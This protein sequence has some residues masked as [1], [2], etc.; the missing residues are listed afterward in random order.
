MTWVA[1][2]LVYGASP[3]LTAVSL[4]AA[5]ASGVSVVLAVLVLTSR[6]VIYS[7][8]LLSR[9]RGQPG[10]FR[11]AGPYLLVDPLFALVIARTTESDSPAR[12]RRYYL[13]AGL[14]IWLVWMPSLA[15]GLLAGP[16]LP[17][18]AALEFALPALLIAFLVP[19]LT[20]RPALAAAAVGAAMGAIA[21][22][23]PGGA[24]LALATVAGTLAAIA[25]E[26]VPR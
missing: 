18:S 25:T 6:G 21:V 3:Y 5:G 13:G 14:A 22:G 12:V 4:T 26:R 20:S 9:M 16:V 23:L 19:G 2:A 17:R 1:G 11:W 15:V 10:W 7:T 8:A 24:G